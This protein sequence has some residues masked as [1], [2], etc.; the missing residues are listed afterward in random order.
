MSLINTTDNLSVA[1]T[2]EH[3]GRA[4]IRIHAGEVV[5]RQWKAAGL[6]IDGFGVVQEEG[7]FGL[8]EL[9]LLAT[10]DE[11]AEFETK[12]GYP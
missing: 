2:A 1:A 3:W 8:I 5:W 4:G 10:K 7:A 12:R 11:G 9:S 6:V